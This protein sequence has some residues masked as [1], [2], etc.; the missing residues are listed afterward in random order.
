MTPPTVD[1]ETEQEWNDKSGVE[2]RSVDIEYTISFKTSS[3]SSPQSSCS[4][5]WSHPGNES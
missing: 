3:R 5:Q 2:V 1:Q 4:W